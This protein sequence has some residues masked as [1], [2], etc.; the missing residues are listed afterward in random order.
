MSSG[1]NH[2]DFLR[3]FLEMR[4]QHKASPAQAPEPTSTK[5]KMKSRGKTAA[6]L[7][8]EMAGVTVAKIIEDKPGKKTVCEYFQQLADRLTTEKMK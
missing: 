6:P 1:G 8:G 4:K 5:G 2:N 3:K 7:E